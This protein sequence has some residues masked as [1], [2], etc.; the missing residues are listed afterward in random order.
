MKSKLLRYLVGRSAEIA[1]M[2]FLV[3]LFFALLT[4]LLFN[5]FP[6]GIS[7][8]QILAERERAERGGRGGKSG[9]GAVLDL[10]RPGER[11][12]AVLTH[13]GND[14][15]SKGAS[16]IAWGTAQEGMPLHDRDAVQTFS[17]SSAQ[18]NF[19]SANYLTMGSNSLVIIKSIEKDASRKVRRSSIVVVEGQLQARIALTGKQALHLN[20]STP[21]ATIKMLPKEGSGP[22]L[23]F[24]ISVNPDHS[25]TIVVTHG[26]AEVSAHGKTMRV[27]ENSGVTIRQG[28]PPKPAAPLP[29]PPLPASPAEGS[30]IR[31][32]EL[33]QQVRFSWSGKAGS[34]FH[35]QLARDRGFG[36]LVVDRRLGESEFLH[37]N[38][39]KGSYFWR[40]S[41]IQEGVEGPMSGALGFEVVQSLAPPALQVTFPAGP[42]LEERFVVSG[43]TEPG[44]RVFVKGKA[45]PTDPQGGFSCELAIRPGLTLVTVEAV[46]PSGN[47]TY[48]SH[49]VQGRF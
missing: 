49:Y 13:L 23:D 7:L 42:V 44:N 31:Y 47:V 34:R 21:T 10:G 17:Q 22:K 4:T 14:V 40:V 30:V 6:A 9:E 25:S 41:S 28:E 19:D 35:L 5:I 11:A 3:S 43:S 37:G 45:V 36:E 18:I 48:Q 12:A 24:K 33:P 20:I 26:Q 27:L 16:S 15:R 46:D 39:K 38:L 29:S 1:V 2:L 32:R 8:T